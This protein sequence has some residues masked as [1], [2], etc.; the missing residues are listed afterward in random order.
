MTQYNAEWDRRLVCAVCPILELLLSLFCANAKLI[1][2]SVS[3]IFLYWPD[4]HFKPTRAQ[5][6]PRRGGK[7]CL[8]QEAPRHNCEDG[9]GLC[10]HVP[11]VCLW[12]CVT[13]FRW[14]AHLFH[15]TKYAS[16]KIAAC[17][18]LDCIR[19]LQI[20]WKRIVASIGKWR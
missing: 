17:E 18:L 20:D 11:C 6:A 13:L 19:G 10:M 9:G 15:V 2:H 16:N 3:N 5:A 12:T 4:Q 14:R 8:F 7:A 1:Q